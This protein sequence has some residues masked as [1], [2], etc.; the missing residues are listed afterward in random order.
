MLHHFKIISKF[1]HSLLHYPFEVVEGNCFL[2]NHQKIEILC[3][4]CNTKSTLE[5]HEFS[6]PKCQSTNLT[7]T[8]GKDMYLMSL[9]ME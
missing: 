6:C 1:F 9:E 8:D 4:D 5:K 7:V 3:Q 2:I